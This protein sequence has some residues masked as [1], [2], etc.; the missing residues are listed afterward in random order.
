MLRKLQK[1]S[2][3]NANQHLALTVH[4]LN[5]T[6]AANTST[7]PSKA[8]VDAHACGATY[9]PPSAA[10]SAPPIGLFNRQHHPLPQKLDVSPKLTV[11]STPQTTQ[12]QTPSPTLSPPYSDSA[13]DSPRT[14]GSDTGTRR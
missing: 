8:D 13:S 11:P 7:A 5:F 2:A 14:S 1:R 3:E 9:L 4:P 6:L 12:S 10:C